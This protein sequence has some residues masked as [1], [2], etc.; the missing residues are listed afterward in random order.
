M[1]KYILGA[2]NV[3]D[4]PKSFSDTFALALNRYLLGVT[5]Q[6]MQQ[7]REEM[8]AMTAEDLLP[9]VTWV[10]EAKEDAACC[11]YGNGALLEGEEGRF[12]S[13]RTLM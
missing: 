11:T 9:F 2:I 8:L 12:A 4:R 6:Q 3:L 5:P 13:I 10:E 7:E 1:T